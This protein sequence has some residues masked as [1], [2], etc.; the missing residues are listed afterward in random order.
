[1]AIES[2]RNFKYET[3]CAAVGCPLKEKCQ[4][5]H[6]PKS[7]VREYIR[8]PFKRRNGKFISCDKFTI[9]R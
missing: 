1:M 4:L 5:H 9:I 7:E 8:A 3:L 6:R 2:K